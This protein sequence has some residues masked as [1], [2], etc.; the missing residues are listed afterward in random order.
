M[1]IEQPT[2]DSPTNAPAHSLSHRVF[3]NDNAAPVKAIVVSS[4][5]NS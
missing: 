1:T 4:G 2:A 3:A 5:R